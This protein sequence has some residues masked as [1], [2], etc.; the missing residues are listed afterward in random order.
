MLKKMK[1]ARHGHATHELTVSG[2]LLPSA[3]TSWVFTSRANIFC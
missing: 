3:R 2:P 1:I